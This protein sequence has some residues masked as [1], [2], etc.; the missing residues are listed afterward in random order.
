MRLSSYPPLNINVGD[1]GS[2]LHRRALRL[3]IN[4]GAASGRE[5]LVA[6][7]CRADQ[8]AETVPFTYQR[9]HR[10]LGWNMSVTRNS[11]LS[12]QPWNVIIIDVLNTVS[13]P[14]NQSSCADYGQHQKFTVSAVQRHNIR[15]SFSSGECFKLKDR[16]SDRRISC[17]LLCFLRKNHS[18]F[19]WYL[20]TSITV[21]KLNKNDTAIHSVL[22]RLTLS[23]WIL[24]TSLWGRK[25]CLQLTDG[26]T[27]AWPDYR[28]ATGGRQAWAWICLS[29]SL[30]FESLHH[31]KSSGYLLGQKCHFSIT[32]TK[33]KNMVNYLSWKHLIF[34]NIKELNLFHLWNVLHIITHHYMVAKLVNTIIYLSRIYYI[35]PR[36]TTWNETVP[37]KHGTQM[38]LH[39]ETH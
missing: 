6:A 25:C 34:S 14:G 24:P 21:G 30:W 32:I 27:K 5:G 13:S 9:C 35:Y 19:T 33:V 18:S 2:W 11:T 29:Q 36:N 26:Q 4:L 22:Y 12:T 17:P 37:W 38:G 7:A 39:M 20:F 16:A 10:S 31:M 3:E 1:L 23:R 28:L 15:V 8:A